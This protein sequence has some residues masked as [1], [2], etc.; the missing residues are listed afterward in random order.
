MGAAAPRLV[1]DASSAT[2]ALFDD[3]SPEPPGVPVAGDALVPDEP[4]PEDGGAPPGGPP[5]PPSPAFAGPDAGV[6]PVCTR[7]AASTAYP[8]DPP[9]PARTPTSRPAA[10]NRRHRPAATSARAP[11]VPRKKSTAGSHG[12]N[13]GVRRSRWAS[14]RTVTSRSTAA[15]TRATGV[16]RSPQSRAPVTATIPA[17][18]GASATV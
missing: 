9:A 5:K 12:R 2:S 15:T 18:A 14:Q 3:A 1:V 4:V 17:I 7:D 6:L 10:T 16:R 11:T 13:V 8:A